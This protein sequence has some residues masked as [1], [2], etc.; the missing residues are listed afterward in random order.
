MLLFG[1]FLIVL[2]VLSWVCSRVVFV[3]VLWGSCVFVMLVC[4]GGRVWVGFCGLLWGVSVCAVLVLFVKR[5]G[6]LCLGVV[7]VS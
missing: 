1:L 4:S 7:V 6:L 5:R 2:V 3:L